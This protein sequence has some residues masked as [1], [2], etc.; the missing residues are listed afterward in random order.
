MSDTK[1]TDVMTRMWNFKTPSHTKLPAEFLKDRKDGITPYESIAHLTND[2]LI[3]IQADLNEQKRVQQKIREHNQAVL[4]GIRDEF[5]QMFKDL[6]LEPMK[7]KDTM[8]AHYQKV[9]SEIEDASHANW[10][11][12]ITF[13]PKIRYVDSENKTHI[14]SGLSSHSTAVWKKELDAAI[15]KIERE[16]EK[17]SSDMFKDMMWALERGVTVDDFDTYQS[18][19]EW[20][21]EARIVD[22]ARKQFEP[23]L[24]HQL[25]H[26]NGKL[27]Y[28]IPGQD[29]CECGSHLVG[30]QIKGGTRS[31]PFLDI[32]SISK[33]P[34]PVY[35]SHFSPDARPARPHPSDPNKD[36]WQASRQSLEEMHRQESAIYMESLKE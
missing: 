32:Y 14:I 12:H 28:Y 17:R 26:E 24:R 33:T 22:E 19:R 36:T 3:R 21:K 35:Y 9:F 29:T 15:A 25:Y 20:L 30:I 34:L 7:N 13:S 10:H 8:Y 11:P 6:G 16:I 18:F 23:G 5:V 31:W 2:D 1:F 4:R 27:C